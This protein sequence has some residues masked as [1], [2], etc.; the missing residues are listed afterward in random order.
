MRLG[1]V[2]FGGVRRGPLR[3][4]QK[5]GGVQMRVMVFPARAGVHRAIV[6]PGRGSFLPPVDARGSDKEEVKRAYVNAI[7]AV[8]GEVVPLPALA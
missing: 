7:Y 8:A 5:Q 3:S 6:V 1:S 4:S 2:P